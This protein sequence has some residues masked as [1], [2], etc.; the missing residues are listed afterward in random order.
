M[1][2]TSRSRA[3]ALALTCA[4]ALTLTVV[5]AFAADKSYTM[6]TVSIDATVQRNGDVTVREQRT[7]DFSGSFS[8]VQWKLLDK[9]SSGIEILG[10]EGPTGRYRRTAAEGEGAGTYTVNDDGTATTLKIFHATTDAQATFT[11]DYV[12]R[13]AAVRWSDTS[14][15]YWQFIGDESE[16]GVGTVRIL[17]H[18]PEAYPKT[19]VQ[20]WAHGPLTGTIYPE[21]GGLVNIAI[22]DL[23][24]YTYVEPRVLFPASGLPEASA[25]PAPRLEEARA[26]EAS[27]ADSANAESAPALL[28]LWQGARIELPG[29]L[30]PRTA[31][32]PASGSRRGALAFRHDR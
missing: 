17:I 3:L 10:V 16:I 29:R 8:W 18:L 6:P 9:G 32:R 19:D 20:V 13:G 23:P 2:P 5:P 30:L 22:D 12:A 27:L 1:F 26:E 21:D 31:R 15:L 24:P 28:P 7:F 14:E 25:N 4:L 11:I